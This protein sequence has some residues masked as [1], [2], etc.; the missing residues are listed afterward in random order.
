MLKCKTMLIEIVNLKQEQVKKANSFFECKL[1]LFNLNKDEQK[2]FFMLWKLLM[3]SR[4]ECTLK[5]TSCCFDCKYVIECLKEVE[6]NYKV[7][8]RE[9]KTTL[10]ICYYLLTFL[11]EQLKVYKNLY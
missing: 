10:Y 11:E 7:Y 8:C 9:R 5:C 1:K 4:K 3:N 6:D 2:I